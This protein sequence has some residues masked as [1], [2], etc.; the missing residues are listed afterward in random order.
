MKRIYLA[1][2]V[3]AIILALSYKLWT[4]SNAKIAST[5]IQHF[6]LSEFKGRIIP[7]EKIRPGTFTIEVSKEEALKFGENAILS[8]GKDNGISIWSPD[9]STNGIFLFYTTT[10]IKINEFF[11][12]DYDGS[13]MT[14]SGY[15]GPAIYFV[16]IIVSIVIIWFV[17]LISPKKPV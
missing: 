7:S 2:F 17:I 16:N 5:D 3:V 14:L 9:S 11:K 1:T 13:I 8:Y 15:F 4:L 6:D 10:K 12:I